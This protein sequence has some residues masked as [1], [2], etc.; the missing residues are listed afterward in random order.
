MARLMSRR[1]EARVV[2][3]AGAEAVGVAVVVGAAAAAVG[4]EWGATEPRS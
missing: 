4:G 3:A 2:E 1:A